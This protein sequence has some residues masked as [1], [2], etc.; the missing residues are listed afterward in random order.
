LCHATPGTPRSP[1][2][3]PA[4]REVESPCV[5]SLSKLLEHH[6][7]GCIRCGSS[8]ASRQP[9]RCGP[10]DSRAEPLLRGSFREKGRLLEPKS[11]SGQTLRATRPRNSHCALTDAGNSDCAPIRALRR[12]LPPQ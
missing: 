6:S 10:E 8:A 4:G 7:G 11:P 5:T 12:T 9:D 1:I 2:T 3:E